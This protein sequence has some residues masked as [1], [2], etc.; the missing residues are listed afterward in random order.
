M[1]LRLNLLT[2][3]VMLAL[4]VT[5]VTVS[6]QSPPSLPQYFYGALKINGADAPAG[7]TVEARV[8]GA[9]NGSFNPITTTVPGKYGDANPLVSVPRLLVQ[10]NIAAGATVEFFINGTKANQTA[11][12]QSGAVTALDLTNSAGA[13]DSAPPSVILT[14]PAPKP[15]AN[16]RA[17][18]TGAASDTQSNI[19]L[20]EYKVDTG[21]WTPAT[22]VDGAFNGPSESF[23]FTT[24]PQTEGSHTIQ[25][26]ATDSAGNVTAAANFGSVTVTVDTAPPTVTLTAVNLNPTTATPATFSGTATDATSSIFSVEFRMDNG[27]WAPASPVDG[28]FNGSI[29]SF[30]LGMSGLAVGAHTVSVRA[31][32]AA[33]NIVAQANWPIIA[34]TVTAPIAAP[35]PQAPIFGGGGGGSGGGGGGGFSG[36]GSSSAPPVI[37]APQVVASP[38]PAAAPSAPTSVDMKRSIETLAPQTA[39]IQLASAP[40]QDAAKAVQDAPAA[41]SAEVISQMAPAISGRLFE[42]ITTARAVDIIDE[43][44][45]TKA[46]QVMEQV[47]AAKAAQIIGQSSNA[48]AAD[49]LSKMAAEKAGQT[50]EGLGVSKLEQVLSAMTAKAL[51]NRLPE[52]SPSAQFA[53]KP[54]VVF[55]ALPQAPTEQLVG[56]L[57]PT[58]GKGL[59]KPTPT[60]PTI[61]SVVYTTESRVGEFSV[62]VGSPAPID[63]IMAKFKQTLTGV[64]V[65]LEQLAVKP[66]HIQPEPPGER[67]NTYLI[68]ALS[69]NAARAVEVGYIRFQV[70]KSWLKANNI[71]KWSILLSRYDAETNSWMSLPTKRVDEDIV[72][73]YYTATTPKFSVFAISGSTGALEQEFQVSGLEVAPA[74]PVAGQPVK[75]TADIANLTT[76]SRNFAVPLW[77]NGVIETSQAVSLGAGAKTKLV[78]TISK[79]I[80][81]YEIRLDRLIAPLQV[82]APPPTPA[83]TPEPVPAIAPTPAPT[84]KPTPLPDTM[85]AS[86]PEPVPA[87]TLQPPAPIAA[88]LPVST[89]PSAPA[90][91]TSTFNF[92]W[93]WVAGLA[94]LI[95]LGVLRI[96]SVQQSK[97]RTH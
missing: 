86:T 39:A 66:P 59:E 16:P 52:L 79:G 53:L 73:V 82:V 32:D 47:G 96:Y 74:N 48:K 78:Y 49:T 10:G 69:Q 76:A 50:M 2:L 60:S 75:I 88:P 8:A 17:T 23:T 90:A 24:L 30:N 1:R 38:P 26:R 93:W 43:M 94:A 63:K 95:I 15:S 64:Q 19:T 14:G 67:L 72:N 37:T 25:M 51:Q 11:P 87:A 13:I 83:P 9:L 33:G 28:A 71:H 68:I 20:V 70:A 36:G 27:V 54:Q 18:L 29:E 85:P 45:G 55:Q 34:F 6:A 91:P 81:N 61:T 57:P 22:A 77:I 65:E 56:E 44:S 62:L 21:I 84:P 4:L 12:F 80:G 42:Q 5:P 97:R 92:S 46:A 41:K 31:T 7:T 3:L 40:L 58:P 35:V 89:P